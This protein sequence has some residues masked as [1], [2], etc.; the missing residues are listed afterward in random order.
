MDLFFGSSQ[1]SGLLC[2][3]SKVPTSVEPGIKKW[4]RRAWKL[5]CY[6]G[7][8]YKNPCMHSPLLTRGRRLGG[9][10]EGCVRQGTEQ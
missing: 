4:T 3:V 9:P 1:G 2:K 8:Y 10:R 5:P 7:V 6:S